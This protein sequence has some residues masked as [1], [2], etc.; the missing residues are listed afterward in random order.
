MPRIVVDGG[1]VLSCAQWRLE[2][3]WLWD[4]SAPLFTKV[5]ELVRLRSRLRLP[6]WLFVSAYPHGKLSP[7]D[8]ESVLAIATIEQVARDAR[9]G[10]F[11]VEMLPAPDELLVR[12]L[13]HGENDRV[14]SEL[15][16]RM[17][18]DESPSDLAAR[19]APEFRNHFGLAPLPS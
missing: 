15:V 6:R 8:L 13:G 18:R 2:T 19:L 12:D 10:L 14:V 9:E 16:V 5:Q 17:P 7:C 11:I 1:L 4:T 3:V